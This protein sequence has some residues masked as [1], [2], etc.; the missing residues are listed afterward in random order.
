[1]STI[2]VGSNGKWMGDKTRIDKHPG[3][4][5]ADESEIGSKRHGIETKKAPTP[6]R[7]ES[8]DL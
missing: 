3:D 7:A 4:R 8:D 1:M 2:R 5:C 6:N